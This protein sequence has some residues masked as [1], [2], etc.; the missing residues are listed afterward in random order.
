MDKHVLK[1]RLINSLSLRYG[2]T[3]HPRVCVARVASVVS[4]LAVISHPSRPR[5]HPFNDFPIKFLMKS[6]VSSHL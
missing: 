3:F 5:G 6:S 4:S 2:V 1:C